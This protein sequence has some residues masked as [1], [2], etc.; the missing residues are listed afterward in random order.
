MLLGVEGNDIHIQSVAHRN[1][2]SGVLDAGP[3]QLGDMYHTVHAADVHKHAVAGHRLHGTGVVLAN[4]NAFP[5]SRLGSLTSLELNRTDGAHHTAA[6][7]IDLGDAQGYSLADHLAELGATRHTAL[8]SGHKHT[9]ALD[10]HD[11]TALV[12]LGDLTFQCGL[13]LTGDLDVFPDLHSVQTLLGEHSIAFHV[14][15]A[16]D[17]GLDFIANLHHILG[18]DIGVSAQLI[19]S[20]VACLLA[21]Q[22]YLDFGGAYRRHDTGYLL[23]CI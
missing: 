15:D 18:L 20:N 7:T 23:S 3:R 14:I 11:D 10:I 9:Y 1:H 19:H 2:L 8:R 4:L 21:A 17:V 13:V 22:I 16:D 5:D 6:G 12:F